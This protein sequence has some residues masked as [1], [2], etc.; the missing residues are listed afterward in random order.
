MTYEL[1]E[2]VAERRLE[3]VAEDGTC[4][5][6]VV[7]IGRPRPDTLGTGEDWCCPHQI[8][9]LG[10]DRVEASFGVDS[11][12]AFLL[13][14][15]ALRLKLTERAE[16]ASVGLDWLGMPDLGLKVDPEVHKLAGPGAGRPDA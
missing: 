11:L 12:Q 3:A 13:S 1:G 9:G 8:L 16:A 4:T 5:P 10:E 6:V 14:V 7:K 15:Y 2:V